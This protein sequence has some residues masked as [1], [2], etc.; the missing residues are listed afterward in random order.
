MGLL[1]LSFAAAPAALRAKAAPAE[2]YVLDEM[3]LRQGLVADAV[4]SNAPGGPPYHA[5]HHFSAPAN[6]APC[7]PR[8]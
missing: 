5:H 7:D 1:A 2:T 4:R 6:Q 3:W 8:M